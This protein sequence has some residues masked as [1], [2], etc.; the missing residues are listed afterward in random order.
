MNQDHTSL[1]EWSREEIASG[2]PVSARSFF[3]RSACPSRARVLLF[4]GA[5]GNPD[6]VRPLAED[7]SAHAI[8]V[9]TPLWPAHG[10]GEEALG[11]IRFQD[12]Q[13]R[14]LEAFDALSGEGALPVFVAGLS[15]GGVMAVRVATR[16]RV[17]GLILLAPAFVPFVGRRILSV[18]PKFLADPRAAGIQ[19]RWQREVRRGIEAT[20]SE[21]SKLH[22]PLLCVHSRE[23]ASVSWKGSKLVVDQAQ[24]TRKQLVLVDGQGHVITRGPNPERVFTPVRDFIAELAERPSSSFLPSGK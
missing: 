12:L 3:L 24:S 15:L 10:R 6:D 23:D 17:A 4:H 18:I 7:L 16:R 8:E 2:V 11:A 22:V 19:V 21:V 13:A 14:A 5:S 9:L 1:L 20:R